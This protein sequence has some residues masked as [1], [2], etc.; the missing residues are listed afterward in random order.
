MTTKLNRIL[1]IDD[2]RAD[3]FVHRRRIRQSAITD[4]VIIKEN[5]REG[6]DYMSRLLD[7]GCYPAP[8]LVFLDLNMPVLNGWEFLDGYEELDDNCKEDIVL[9]VLT[10]SVAERDKERARAYDTVDGF[11]EKPLTIDKLNAVLREYFPD[12]V[13]KDAAAP[14]P[15]ARSGR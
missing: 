3:N 14:S 5:G 6:L 12:R 10:T 7:D 11:L 13:A 8:D 9:I 2:S 15:S 1:L 4:E